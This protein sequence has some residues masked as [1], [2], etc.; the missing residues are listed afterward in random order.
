[1]AR[2][3]QSKAKEDRDFRE[4]KRSGR[5]NRRVSGGKSNTGA[6]AMYEDTDGSRSKSDNDASWYSQDPALLRDSAS[7][8]F[9]Y[10]AGGRIRLSPAGSI[11]TG[12]APTDITDN[13]LFSTPGCFALYL[14]PTLGWNEVPSDPINVAADAYYTLIRSA[15]SGARNY[16]A[17]D[18]MMKTLAMAEIYS[19]I[20]F[21]QRLYGLSTLYSPVNKYLPDELIK[22][23]GVDPVSLRQNRANFRYGINILINKAA[24]LAVP[25]DKTLFERKAFLYRDVYVE[26]TSIKDQMYMYVPQGFLSLVQMTEG[27][28]ATHLVY[29]AFQVST[30][31][32]DL[33]EY[34]DLLDYGESLLSGVYG[35]QDIATMCGDILKAYGSNIVKLAELP[36][37]YPVIPVFNIGVLEQMKNATIIN[38]VDFTSL[39]VTQD[40]VSANSPFIV[41]KPQLGVANNSTLSLLQAQAQKLYTENRIMTTTTVDTSPELVMESSRLMAIATGFST[42]LITG[43]TN[44]TIHGRIICGT[45]L[46]VNAKYVTAIYTGS[47]IAPTMRQIG[48]NDYVYS[49]DEV[50]DTG[51]LLVGKSRFWTLVQNGHFRFRPAQHYICNATGEGN[52]MIDLGI[53]FDVDNYT[54]IDSD[55]LERLHQTAIISLLHSPLIAKLK[56]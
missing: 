54:L 48:Y 45:E 18:L 13:G 37:V 36:D 20:V 22:L 44:Y 10:S 32:N 3:K 27:E 52:N 1:M 21:L 5:S 46:C 15:N 16:D 50:A 26:G 30:S 43:T 23:C 9:S 56:G 12:T 39:T 19:Y 28:P 53:N 2:R 11:F 6:D 38:H 51:A 40:N 14:A 29:S 47:N 24:S 8:P 35:Q 17:P 33:Q 31:T 41:S 55:I 7:I 34:T 49:F 42:A 25:A 4:T